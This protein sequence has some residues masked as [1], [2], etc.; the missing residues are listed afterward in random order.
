MCFKKF[1]RGFAPL[2]AD[3]FSDILGRKAGRA[4]GLLLE[5]DGFLERELRGEGVVGVGQGGVT[6]QARIGGG[7]VGVGD[8][9]GEIIFRRHP[10]G[11]V[12][13]TGELLRDLG[14][15]LHRIGGRLLHGLDLRTNHRLGMRLIENLKRDFFLSGERIGQFLIA[16]GERDVDLVLVV[17]LDRFALVERVLGGLLSAGSVGGIVSGERDRLLLNKLGG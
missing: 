13:M 4:A 11:H 12:V 8:L 9:F 16:R 1:E 6:S 17:Q 3:Q 7:L 15:A 5:H 2:S 10:L 14:R